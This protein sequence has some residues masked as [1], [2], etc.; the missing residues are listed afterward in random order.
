MKMKYHFTLILNTLG[1]K[2]NPL[3]IV[4]QD[5]F[6]LHSTINVEALVWCLMLGVFLLRFMTLGTKINHKYRNMS[7]LITEQ[8]R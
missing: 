2:K 5:S 1:V 3:F 6:R 7:V 8:V 4:P